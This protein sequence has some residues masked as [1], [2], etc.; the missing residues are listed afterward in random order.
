MAEREL[1][2]LEQL[3]LSKI[4]LSDVQSV[5]NH[6]LRRA[7]LEVVSGLGKETEHTSHGAH[8]NHYKTIAIEGPLT[9][10][11]VVNRG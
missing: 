7:L 5:K 3:D 1:D 8:S 11:P 9:D 6:V 4:T 2:K 10:N